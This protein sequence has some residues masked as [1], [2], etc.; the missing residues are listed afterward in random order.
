MTRKNILLISFDDAVAPW[1]YKTVF[2]EPL[3]TPNLDRFCE[4]STAFH[5]AYA[6]APICGPSRASMMTTLMPHE[7]GILDNEVYAFDRITPQSIWT[8]LLNSGGY[9]CSS[10]GK[11]H[12]GYRPL[13]PVNHDVLY[14][15]GR[16]KFPDDMSLPKELRKRSKAF[17]GFKKGWGTPDGIDDDFYY[18]A[19]SADSAVKFLAEYDGDQPFYRE[20]GFFSPH[21]PC[22]TPARFKEMYDASNLR[23][24]PEW[25]GY[26][27]ES[28]FIASTFPENEDF[29]SEEYWQDSI[30]NYFS[31]Y[32]HGD[33]H[34]GRVMDAL[35]NSRHAQNTIV[36]VVSDHGFH[37]GNRNLF[38]K[39]T[40]WEQSLRVP[41]IIFDP[42]NP[43]G[44]EVHNPVAMID[45]GPTVL[46]FAGIAPAERRHGRSLRPFLHG[47]RDASR[48]IPSFYKHHVSIRKGEYRIIRYDDGSF[49]LF[50]VEK[51]FWQLRDLGI[52]HEEFEPMYQALKECSTDCGFDFQNAVGAATDP[53]VGGSALQPM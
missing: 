22:A 4:I 26:V 51:D 35:K 43:V 19:K 11:V 42:E 3:R 41:F 20:V 30:R 39:T 21:V 27:P 10:G 49:Q 44:Q 8:F 2:K 50:N 40:L 6:Q 9:Y 14:S 12:H 17:G 36:V 24:P 23:R 13:K 15:D 46:D 33:Y 53:A 47:E 32:S 25:N 34:F 5:A 1:P 45:L 29:R 28:D 18:D 48:V 7:T 16:K 37:L 38:R 31:A 52:Q